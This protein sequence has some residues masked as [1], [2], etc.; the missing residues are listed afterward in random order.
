MAND[1]VFKCAVLPRPEYYL[2]KDLKS[3]FRLESDR[4][5]VLVALKSMYELLKFDN[6]IGE[7]IIVNAIS[8][9]R[10]VKETERRYEV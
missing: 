8:N 2:M 1:R 10:S 9:L 6:G 4:E 3:Y 7:G 5:V